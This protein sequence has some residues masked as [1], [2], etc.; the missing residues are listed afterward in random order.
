[1]EQ[2]AGFVSK[3]PI[4]GCYMVRE[5]DEVRKDKTGETHAHGNFPNR[6]L[7]QIRS[8]VECARG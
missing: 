5:M 2:Q 3:V 1:M 6:R 4:C 7:Q 8:Q